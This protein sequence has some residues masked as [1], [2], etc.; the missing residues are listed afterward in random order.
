M[1]KR[2]EGKRGQ[3]G[4]RG[5]G[6]SDVCVLSCGLWCG[7]RYGDIG[8]ATARLAKAY[9]MTVIALRR[10]LRPP[11]CISQTCVNVYE[12]TDLT[13]G[14]CEVPPLPPLTMCFVWGVYVCVSPLVYVQKR[15]PAESSDDHLV[16]KVLPP[17]QVH[18]TKQPH[19]FLRKW[20]HGR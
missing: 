14:K 13:W 8:M 4:G 15:R 18:N 9:G 2:E 19:L 16:D 5:R 17:T 1:G 20:G 6:R 3:W 7:N 10:C 12:W 11:Q